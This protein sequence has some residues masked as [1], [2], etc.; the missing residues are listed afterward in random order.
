MKVH[1]LVQ[2]SPEWLAHRV[3]HHNASDAPAMMGCS[4]YKTRSQL[5]AELATGIGQAVTPEMQRIFDE[6]HRI[7][8]LARPLAEEII[9]EDLYPVTG[10]RGKRSASFDGLTMSQRIASE[11]KSLNDR[12]RASFDSMGDDV[13]AG[14]LLPLDYRV[15]MEQQSEVSECEKVLFMATKW[16]GATLVEARHCWYYPDPAL[17]A[18]IIA[19]WEQLEA[20]VCAYVP[21]AATAVQLVGDAGP[22][23][24]GVSVKVE[25]ALVVTTNLDKFEL[26]LRNFIEHRLITKPKTDQDFADLDVQ[27]K[28]MKGAESALESSDAS[29]LAQIAPVDTAL[30]HSALL[31]ELVRKHRLLSEKL[32]TSEKDR[33]KLEIV[34]T[35]QQA[36]RDHMAALNERLGKPYMPTI[37]A[38]FAGEIKG[39][40]SL[41][42]ME[43][44]VN[45]LL[46]NSKLQAN[47]IADKID[48]NLKFMRERAVNHAF[49]FS[50][51]STI[52]LKAP[53][54]LQL[55]VN[56]R[57]T[58]HDAAEAARLQKIADDA[59]DK[60]K[61]D[62]ADAF[63]K[64]QA[65]VAAIRFPEPEAAPAPAVQ[66]PAPL[67]LVAA[68][69]AARAAIAQEAPPAPPAAPAP[70][71]A[72]ATHRSYVRSTPPSP[73]REV[74]WIKTA[75]V[76]AA[77]ALPV[78]ADLL[79]S[80]G[81]P[82]TKRAGPGMWWP[83]HQLEGMH[84]ALTSHSAQALAAYRA[85][86]TVAA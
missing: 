79:A 18:Q 69:N 30:K 24:P 40:R 49:L 65:A 71:P 12:L 2:G 34:T 23:L 20:D 13:N 3:N 60:A 83:D 51:T 16:N 39:M 80:V 31:C 44:V 70:A 4:P 11:H 45:T 68:N 17:R 7:E 86:E 54:D 28:A 75:D 6:G 67:S 77:L 10:S 26:S 35:G 73:A 76:A 82:G 38:D 8:A 59:A 37:T 27:I 48:A 58:E 9:G 14:H 46:V 56:A 53:E 33:R 41:D 22:A 15:Q 62:A 47:A 42:K 50:D 43:E 32:L 55:L 52:V 5:V 63:A 25:G 78:N 21:P 36:F 19:G 57:I 74:V 61:Q 29:M 85:R 66:S 81:F 1:E 72:P 64:L 84:T